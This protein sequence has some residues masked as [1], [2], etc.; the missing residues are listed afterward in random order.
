MI[1]SP[2]ESGAN[3]DNGQNFTQGT[4]SFHRNSPGF[5]PS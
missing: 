3:G 5:K 1:Q 2:M 4:G